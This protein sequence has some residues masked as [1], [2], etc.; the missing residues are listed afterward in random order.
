VLFILQVQRFES[1]DVING[2]Q[3]FPELLHYVNAK[4]FDFFGANELKEL[5]DRGVQEVVAAVVLQQTLDY[6]RHQIA[7]NDVAVVELVFEANEFAQ[8]SQSG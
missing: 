5:D 7:V 2:F 4:A 8:K 6:R 3:L 1:A